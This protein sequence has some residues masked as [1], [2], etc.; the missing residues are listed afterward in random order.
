MTPLPAATAPLLR[1]VCL[2]TEATLVTALDDALQTLGANA[3]RL[4]ATDPAAPDPDL[5]A[6]AD[7]ILCDTLSDALGGAA[8]NVR[9]VQFL[10]S[11]AGDIETPAPFADGRVTICDASGIHVSACADHVL[12]LL[13]AFARGLPAAL[14]GSAV[15]FDL[16]GKTAGIVGAGRVGQAV[17]TRCQ[18]FG[19][20][21]V[22][23]S[24]EVN[25]PMPGMN[26]LLSHLRYHDLILASDVVVL[27]LPLT[28]DTCLTFGEDEIE[29]IKKSALVLNA[30]RRGLV[31]ESWLLRALQNR[32]IGGAGLSVFAD[33]ALPLDSPFR[34]LPNCIVSSHPDDDA[35]LHRTRL[36]RFVA[37]QAGRLLRGEPL[38]DRLSAP[39]DP[40]AFA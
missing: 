6:R 39:R 33:E 23:L 27:A 1:L 19:M 21:T 25:K 38:Q 7:G 14:A 29:I 17:G 26:V 9:W 37:A 10:R 2:S 40:G 12:A 3:V 24:R 11:D 34:G 32:W 28:P 30:G 4:N 8:P 5:L 31:D 35:A 16:A 20:Q 18:A 13:L 36:A 22:G 15:P